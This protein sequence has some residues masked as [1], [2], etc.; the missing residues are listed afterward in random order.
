MSPLPCPLLTLLVKYGA[1]RPIIYIRRL[2]WIRAKRQIVFKF[3]INTSL[4]KFKYK[5]VHDFNKW[6]TI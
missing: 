5:K 3:L 2:P 4:T 1:L 6:R